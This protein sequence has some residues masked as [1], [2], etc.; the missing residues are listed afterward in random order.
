M[1]RE[2]QL[3]TSKQEWPPYTAVLKLFEAKPIA[4]LLNW[5]PSP[6]LLFNIKLFKP[7][8]SDWFFHSQNVFLISNVTIMKG[9]TSVRV[10][11]TQQLT[12]TMLS[13]PLG[14]ALLTN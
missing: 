8:F 4:Q 7:H 13:F 10:D 6:T 5:A 3:P 14:L 2:T 9:E 11:H 12:Q 1:H